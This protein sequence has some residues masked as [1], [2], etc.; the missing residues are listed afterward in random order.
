MTPLRSDQ[1][2]SWRSNAERDA[3]PIS[4]TR[5]AA[6]VLLSEAAYRAS[7]LGHD[8]WEFAVEIWL[9]FA[10]GLSPN[11]IRKLVCQGAL[12]HRYETTPEGASRRSF[13]KPRAS[14][15][16]RR[17]CF[18]LSERAESD[19]FTPT[20]LD[21]DHS[22][23]LRVHKG[24]DVASKPH[25]NPQRHELTFDGR[26]VKAF[27][28]PAPNQQLI[29]QVFE[30]EDWPDRIA[31]PLPL[32]PGLPAKRRLHETIQ[33]LNAGQS[34]RLI[35]FHGD[36]TGEGVLWSCVRQ[37]ADRVQSDSVPPFAPLRRAS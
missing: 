32:E 17:S 10:C 18:V 23:S 21:D 5:P 2:P 3:I 26:V 30:E 6:Y 7:N 22:L 35:V 11:D 20:L 8:R 31:D 16:T 33:S 13:S 15:L 25:W 4:A 19:D 29:L 1:P 34:A 24:P 14:R 37:K 36:G 27:H 28:R 12:L 9:L